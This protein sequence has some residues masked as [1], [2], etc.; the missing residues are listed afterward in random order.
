M[1]SPYGHMSAEKSVFCFASND[2]FGPGFL[3]AAYLM[4][5]LGL[6][7][8]LPSGSFLDAPVQGTLL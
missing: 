6:P 5:Q 7:V 3:P 2:F 4:R 8:A 1:A